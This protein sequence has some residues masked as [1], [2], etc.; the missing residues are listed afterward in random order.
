M[1]EQ[2]G[3][4]PG[5]DDD[6]RPAR[7]KAWA[8]PD[9]A[10]GAGA[11]SA[12]RSGSRSRPRPWL[13]TNLELTDL[14]RTDFHL[15]GAQSAHHRISNREA[16]DRERPHCRGSQ[17]QRRHDRR[18][19]GSGSDDLR[20]DEAAA[21]GGSVGLVPNALRPIHDGSLS[22]ISV[23]FSSS[24]PSRQ[25]CRSAASVPAGTRAR[26]GVRPRSGQ[27]KRDRFGARRPDRRVTPG[28]DYLTRYKG[29]WAI[30]LTA[31]SRVLKSLTSTVGFRG[32]VAV[33]G[34]GNEMGGANGC[35]AEGPGRSVDNGALAQSTNSNATTCK[36]ETRPRPPQVAT[37]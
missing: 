26:D 27:L 12:R 10:A 35:T 25:P 28:R 34:R 18:C 9:T 19:D 36:P 29:K 31:T 21:D 6:G 5:C 4:G 37:L 1:C 11:G 7:A 15:A 13:P 32:W 24:R 14:E 33:C 16:A 8:F 2:R 30:H 22:S 17:R 3:P 20:A 23:S